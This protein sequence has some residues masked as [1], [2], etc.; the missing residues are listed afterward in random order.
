MIT[1]P[2]S[3]IDN[4][5]VIPI[6]DK[7][8]QSHNHEPF[9]KDL[10]V[11]G[12][13]SEGSRKKFEIIKELIIEAHE[14]NT[15]SDEEIFSFLRHVYILQFDNAYINGINMSLIFS[16]L[17]VCYKTYQKN[18]W[19]PIFEL[20]SKKK[21]LGVEI[22]KEDLPPELKDDR[23]VLPLPYTTIEGCG[24]GRIIYTYEDEKVLSIFS[25][26]GGW[27]NGN[28]GD[29]EAVKSFVDT[30]Y[31]GGF[32]KWFEEVQKMQI[33]KS[34]NIVM[35]D[36]IWGV[37]NPNL[38]I[39][40]AKH[41]SDKTL[42]A[43]SDLVINIVKEQDPTLDLLPEQRFA[44]SV[45]GKKR[46]Y[47]ETLRTSVLG[48]LA[49]L[50]NN[51]ECFI[52][53][54]KKKYRFSDT[55]VWTALEKLDWRDVC[56]LGNLIQ[57]LAE[58]SPQAFLDSIESAIKRD[59]GIFH[60]IMEQ[61]D[62][63]FMTNNHIHNLIWALEALA[64]VP[65]YFLNAVF[66]LSYIAKGPDNSIFAPPFYSLTEIFLPW[67]PNTTATADK[68]IIAMNM[69]YKEN[70][71]VAWKLLMNIFPQNCESIIGTH[72]PIWIKIDI[73]SLEIVSDKE[74]KENIERYIS[75]AI[76]IAEKDN[77]RIPDLIGQ[78]SFLTPNSFERLVKFV[79]N[80][81]LE[82]LPEKIWRES[83]TKLYRTLI[84]FNKDSD[85]GGEKNVSKISSI[86]KMIDEFESSDKKMLR[87]F[88]FS[89][90]DL[91]LFKR[92]DSAGERKR[93]GEERVKAVREIV[94]N[95]GVEDLVDF[96]TTVG[97]PALVGHMLGIF[98]E[99]FSDA[100]LPGKM[101]SEHMDFIKG[102]VKSRYGVKGNEWAVFSAISKWQSEE[103]VQFL[104][105]L[106]ISKEIYDV[107]SDLTMDEKNR[108]WKNVEVD[109]YDVEGESY[110][111]VATSL[112]EVG[113]YDDSF[114]IICGVVSEEKNNS[115][116][117]ADIIVKALLDYPNSANQRFS[118]DLYTTY[119]LIKRVQTDEGIDNE[120]KA[121]IE[122]KYFG[123][124]YGLYDFRPITLEKKL[125][126]DP[127]FFCYILDLVYGANKEKKKK[128][129]K[130]Y[131]LLIPQAYSLLNMWKLPPGVDEFGRFSKDLFLEW[132]DAV[133]EESS[134]LGLYEEAMFATGRVLSWAPSDKGGFWIDTDLADILND[135]S[136]DLIRGLFDAHFNRNSS[137]FLGD[138]TVEKQI[139]KF[140]DMAEAAEKYGYR[141]LFNGANE[142][143]NYYISRKERDDLE[144]SFGRVGFLMRK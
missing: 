139:K 13:T 123:I 141:R 59:P 95:D 111:G 120:I 76:D 48:S 8:H 66:L 137:Y 82:Q 15:P 92:D 63:Y 34:S 5:C 101:D 79:S 53:C 31:V 43:F 35:T 128:I 10:E 65:E 11:R 93:I 24:E 83:L 69:L 113:R 132:F 103:K 105:L 38:L 116:K 6:L 106:P 29:V 62:A 54:S 127:R 88:L 100:I 71:D 104:S 42:N 7:I 61:H 140:G 33:Q 45:Y 78:M 68:R 91:D 36:N 16:L 74:Y 44:A 39:I 58:A 122:W 96:S 77:L 70:P 26:L 41:I 85:S 86:Q 131:S 110:V 143:K 125:S 20:V 114:K 19:A 72:R 130:K 97:M 80:L 75:F 49:I 64:W 90:Y 98:E 67:C 87:R 14:P 12:Y 117:N 2:L 144:S 109:F 138:G 73:E 18:L 40:V 136:E 133:K 142:L 81:N 135:D 102:Y 25:L 108:Y 57:P 17:S 126:H 37:S 51:V 115:G 32:T 9:Y 55:L 89:F 134:N 124:L 1:G 84:F 94:E 23:L 60:Q 3:R 56:N 28:A 129:S 22:V 4:D 119:K 27:D 50:S 118:A 47:S 107:V 52:N 46:K 21:S 121:H 99:E 30:T 112:M